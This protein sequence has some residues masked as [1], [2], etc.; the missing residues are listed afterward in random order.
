[1]LEKE[2]EKLFV[3]EVKKA[4]GKAYKFTSPGSEGV[5]D[6]LV[7]FPGSRIGFVEL[8]QQGKKPSAVQKVRIKELESRDCFVTVL[9]RPNNI[10]KVIQAIKDYREEDRLFSELV[11]RRP[12]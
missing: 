12:K 5:P 4:G 9:D 8:K 2:L 3:T 7:V 1:M 11:N 6:R 10:P